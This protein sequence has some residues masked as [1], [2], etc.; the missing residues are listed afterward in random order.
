MW[1]KNCET[2]GTPW[3]KFTHS[4]VHP[5]V[6]RNTYQHCLLI[7]TSKKRDL[8]NLLRQGIIPSEY[9]SFYENLPLSN[10]VTDYTNWIHAERS[11]QIWC[12]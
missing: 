2:K 7:S 12:R 8:I 9:A 3:K 10:S 6:T 1:K 4:D 5:V 11:L